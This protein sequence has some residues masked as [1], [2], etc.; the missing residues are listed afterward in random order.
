M[1]DMQRGKRKSDRCGARTRKGT[2][3]KAK[4]HGKGGRCR[5]HGGMST[6]PRTL[7][8]RAKL[9]AAVSARWVRWREDRDLH[10]AGRGRQVAL[11]RLVR[12]VDRVTRA[13]IVERR[14]PPPPS[15]PSNTPKWSTPPPCPIMFGFPDDDEVRQASHQDEPT[16][17]V[18]RNDKSTCSP[19]YRPPENFVSLEEPDDDYWAWW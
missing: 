3:C 7:E 11:A 9:A 14:S 4:G 5:N 19:D 16:P 18:R 13:R 15:P 12:K 17:L 10:Q 2:P 6:G 1:R 8:G